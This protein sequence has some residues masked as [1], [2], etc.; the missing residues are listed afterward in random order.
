M[1]IDPT[2]QTD[3][4]LQSADAL[5]AEIRRSEPRREYA[6]LQETVMAD[7]TNRTLLQEYKRLQMQLQMQA[8]GGGRAPP[9]DTERFSR[10]SALLYM[11]ADVQ[12]YLLAEMKLQKTLADVIQRVAEAAGIQMDIPQ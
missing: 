11:N 9:E 12:A 5:A 2:G 1:D 7:G 8:M 6:R 3:R 4:I 10:L